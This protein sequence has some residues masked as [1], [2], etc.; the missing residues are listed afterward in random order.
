MATNLQGT[1]SKAAL[2]ATLGPSVS[3][4]TVVGLTVTG[5]VTI[6]AASVILY[7]APAQLAT[8]TPIFGAQVDA[9][10]IVESDSGSYVIVGAADTVTMRRLVP[11]GTLTAGGNHLRA[12][13]FNHAPVIGADVPDNQ[14]DLGVITA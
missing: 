3:R 1:A 13:F 9:F 12:A 6:T 11:A 8:A 14:V 5:A 4:D 10:S 7:Q 2:G